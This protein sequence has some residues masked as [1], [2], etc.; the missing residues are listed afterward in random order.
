MSYSKS[1]N[2]LENLIKE[3]VE[4]VNKIVKVTKTL[5]LL[6]RYLRIDRDRLTDEN[7][8]RTQKSIIASIFWQDLV[9]SKI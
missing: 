5:L 3:I 7:I 4:K 1:L 8:C 2:F 9:S 6:S